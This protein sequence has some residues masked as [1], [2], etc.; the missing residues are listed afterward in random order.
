MSDKE[1]LKTIKNNID[2][3]CK[4]NDISL[5]KLAKKSN[6]SI[7]IINNIINENTNDL[8]IH[9]IN[10][11]AKILKVDIVDLLKK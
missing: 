3:Y 5:E 1:L 9:I 2:K 6:I 11:I 8:E 7:D 10:K 4:I